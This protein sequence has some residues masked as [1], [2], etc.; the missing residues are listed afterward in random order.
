MKRLVSLVFLTLFL[1]SQTIVSQTDNGC[2]LKFG[3]K[4][5]A[6]KAVKMRH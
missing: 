3:S 1:F 6:G 4:P 2:N 5:V